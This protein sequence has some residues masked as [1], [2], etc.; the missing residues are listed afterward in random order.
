MGTRKKRAAASTTAVS[1]ASPARETQQAR[2]KYALAGENRVIRIDRSAAH[3]SAAHESIGARIDQELVMR[4]EGKRWD[5][6]VMG[7]DVHKEP[8]AHA[9]VDPDG[10]VEEHVTE[11]TIAGIQTIITTCKIHGVKMVAMESTAE[12][13]LLVYWMLMEAG[14]P[15]M[16]VNSK[17]TKAV[18]GVKTDKLDARRIAF[19]L[20][21]GRLRP[22]VACDR[23]QSTIQT[24]FPV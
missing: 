1:K 9:I 7:I 8:L 23:E 16:V 13:W 3:E 6:R 4:A 18:M 21:D 11:N 12:Y 2:Q 24:G 5:D 14:I 19:A 20:R 22:S 10:L 17:Q 15:V